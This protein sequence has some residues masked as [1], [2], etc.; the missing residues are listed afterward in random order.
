[1]HAHI[2]CWF[3]RKRRPRN[4]EPIPPLEA[5]REGAA[6]KQ[7]PLTDSVT[8]LEDYHEDSVYLLSEVA[9][10]SAEMQRPDVSSESVK[11]GGF[12]WD[13]LR[14]AGLARAV[15]IKLNCLHVCS[16]AYCLLNRATCRFFFPWPQ[17]PYQVAQGGV[18]VI[19]LICATSLALRCGA[20]RD[21]LGLHTASCLAKDRVAAHVRRY[22]YLVGSRF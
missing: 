22:A 4:W 12:D 5:K 6:P 16:P 3:K 15:L 14:I 17:R 9:R 8:K 19:C 13:T 2:L 11:W 7:R 1:M 10:V 21:S 20:P 18:V